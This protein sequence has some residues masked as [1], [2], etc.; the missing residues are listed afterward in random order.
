MDAS[1]VDALLDTLAA[2]PDSAAV[3]NPYRGPLGE[4]RLQNLRRYLEAAGVP[5]GVAAHGS[6]GG[7]ADG[8]VI[9]LVG[10]APGYRG[11]AVTGVP[12]TSR[13][14]LLGDAGRWGLFAPRAFVAHEDL[15]SP[16]AEATAT[17]VW[18]HL[19]VAM[20]GLAGPPLLWNAV[21]FHPRPPRP[22]L[23]PSDDRGASRAPDPAAEGNRSPTTAEVAEGASYL[24]ALL[25]LVPG[26]RPIAVGQVAARAIAQLGISPLAVLRHPAHGG[27]TAFTAQLRRIGAVL[28][29]DPPDSVEQWHSS[30]SATSE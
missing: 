16:W 5:H 28:A 3:G 27:A 13:Q 1:A 30:G 6:A 25:H 24:R 18:R 19:P 22:T 26:V 2:R 9:A 12:F 15:G 8:T 14:V 20:A 10:E 29:G 7:A 17:L 11:C 23:D 4:V 21:P